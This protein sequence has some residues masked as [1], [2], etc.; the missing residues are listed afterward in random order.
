[1]SESQQLSASPKHLGDYELI[2]LLSEGQLTRT[3]K[4]QKQSIGRTVLLNALKPAGY[5]EDEQR[6]AFLADIRA[7]AAIDLPE[8]ATVYEASFEQDTIYYTREE[9]MGETLEDLCMRGDR[10]LKPLEI[11]KML[12]KISKVALTLKERNMATIP[13]SLSDIHLETYDEPR[14]SNQAVAGPLIEGAE[15]QDRQLLGEALADLVI[16]GEPAATRISALTNM[17]ADPCQDPPLTWQHVHKLSTEVLS[18][19]QDQGVIAEKAPAPPVAAKPQKK[20]KQE[21]PL[22]ESDRGRTSMGIMIPL[23]CVALVGGGSYIA[24]KH[25]NQPEVAIP[26]RSVIV[27]SDV[28]APEDKKSLIFSVFEIDRH[29]VTLAEYEE[30]LQAINYLPATA[31]TAFDHPKQPSTKGDHTP[32]GW[33]EILSAAADAGSYNGRSIS[34]DHPVTGV[35]WWDAYA[36][37]R[38]KNRSLPTLAQFYAAS[39]KARI[40]GLDWGPADAGGSE[41]DI[42]GLTSNATEWL[43]PDDTASDRSPI[44][45]SGSTLSADDQPDSNEDAALSERSYAGLER[46]FRTVGKPDPGSRD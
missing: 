3:Y 2:K 33:N 14:L 42:Q 22:A 29:E 16:L 41:S 23:L 11:A 19:L 39:S 34:M 37:S 18:Q 6:E 1:M 15:L 35:D 21:A 44:Y 31:K 45:F 10:V 5:A 20:R 36:Y 7:K 26:Q 40:G 46:G 25:F 13:L 43:L 4:A 27:A 8:L 24:W 17:M 12:Q 28:F 32:L 38:W 9:L 30:F